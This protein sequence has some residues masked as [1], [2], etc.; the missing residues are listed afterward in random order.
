MKEELIL[1][2]VSV[3]RGRM[4]IVDSLS[5]SFPANQIVALA[6]PN[7]A[8]KS[9]LL[10][11]I[12]GTL[13]HSGSVRWGAGPLNARSVGFMPQHCCTKADLSVLQT[14]L[15]G[16]HE[17]L[18]FRVGQGELEQAS[19]ML[20]EFGLEALARRQVGTLSGG[21]QQLVLLAQRLMRRP[22][23][24]I[25][26]ES[27]C[28]LDIRHQLTVL[29][30]LRK[31]VARTGALVVM[32]IHDLNLAA[33]AAD[34]LLLLRAGRLMAWGTA[35]DVLTAE[36]VA[37][38]YDVEAR[39]LAT[40]DG[41]CVLPIGPRQPM[42]PPSPFPHEQRAAGNVHLQHRVAREHTRHMPLEAL[43]QRQS[44]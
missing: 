27:T 26:D 21:Q 2:G 31:Y 40:D 9:T 15:L 24:L 12:A 22:K 10:G 37:A 19:E 13:A 20:H 39:V 23:L 5:L 6:G 41:P 25:L 29:D 36:N 33:R 7:G 8:G 14:L 44:T 34:I 35:A 1:D 17:Q 42:K 28:A 4:T 38:I 18:G 32:A 43:D 30:I 11:A 3:R 16:C